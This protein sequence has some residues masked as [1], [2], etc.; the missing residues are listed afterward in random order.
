M[1]PQAPGYRGDFW[2]SRDFG[3]MLQGPFQSVGRAILG[4]GPGGAI[5]F[6]CPELRAHQCKPVFLGKGLPLGVLRMIQSFFSGSGST[7]VLLYEDPSKLR[8]FWW[9]PEPI[10][11]CGKGVFLA[12]LDRS[13]VSAWVV[14]E[15][16]K[17]ASRAS[18]QHLLGDRFISVQS[19]VRLPQGFAHG[20]FHF[21]EPGA[22]HFRGILLPIGAVEHFQ[23]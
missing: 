6:G 22:G 9:H 5:F 14:K 7:A 12:G 16:S 19:R 4:H 21:C 8:R 13:K 20:C 2:V 23:R 10:M 18:Q 17:Q 15:P 11:G 1:A 3:E